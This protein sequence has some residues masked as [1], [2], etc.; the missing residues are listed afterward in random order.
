MLNKERLKSRRKEMN[1]S[2]KQMAEMIGGTQQNYQQIET[3]NTVF[4]K[5]DTIRK[6]AEVLQTT[7][8]YLTDFD[9]MPL[10]QKLSYSDK[11]KVVTFI[12]ELINT[13]KK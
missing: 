5:K 8:D 2:Q 7:E 13:D 3:K 11:E 9:I 12:T 6:L 10:Y 4:N 1:F